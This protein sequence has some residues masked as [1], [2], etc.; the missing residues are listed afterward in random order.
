LWIVFLATGIWHG[1]EW[2]F[3]LWGL[4]HGL[5]IVIEKKI[6]A[7]KFQGWPAHVYT[8][9]VVLFGWVL[10]RAP[11]MKSASG[12]AKAALGLGA[13]KRCLSCRGMPTGGNF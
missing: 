10:F 11:N 12:Y 8:L 4:W 7:E 2:T 1:A 13:E 6:G 3:V 9:A 5:F